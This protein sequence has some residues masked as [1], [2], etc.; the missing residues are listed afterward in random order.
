MPVRF[1]WM[2]IVGRGGRS[3]R[4]DLWLSGESVRPGI[5]IEVLLVGV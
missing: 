5:D 3:S 1:E 4:H 2:T